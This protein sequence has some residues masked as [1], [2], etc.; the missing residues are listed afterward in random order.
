MRHLTFIVITLLFLA[1]TFAQKGK[2]FD[3]HSLDGNITLH[4]E[5]DD[6]TLWSVQH[7]GQQLIA[8]S[9]LSLQLQNEVLGD[10]PAITS[11]KTEKEMN[12]INASDYIKSTIPDNYKPLTLNCKG[13]Y[14]I[15]FRVYN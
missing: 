5:T 2:T 9:T 13:D 6:K 3:V 12:T 14:G 1:T 8:P 4:V 15:I 10:K 7:K 11:S